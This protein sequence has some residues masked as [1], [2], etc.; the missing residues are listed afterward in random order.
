VW[1]LQPG[2]AV[3]TRWGNEIAPLGIGAERSDRPVDPL[4]GELQ[5]G[6]V[7]TFRDVDGVAWQ[8]TPCGRLE[9]LPA[10]A[11]NRK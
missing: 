5:S 9:E 6:S 2:L 10:A 11:R 3:R 1:R 8:R 7:L 4:D